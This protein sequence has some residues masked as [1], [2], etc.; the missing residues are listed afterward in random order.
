MPVTFNNIISSSSC[1]EEFLQIFQNAFFQQDQLFLE[2]H[3]AILLI[4]Y[5]NSELAPKIEGKSLGRV[6]N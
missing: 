3:R 5:G 6:I 1:E 4:C 2:A